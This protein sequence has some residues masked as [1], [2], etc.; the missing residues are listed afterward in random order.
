MRLAFQYVIKNKGIDSEL[1]YNYTG[2][3]G[4]CW[5]DATHRSIAQIDSWTAVPAGNEVRI[6]IESPAHM[7]PQRAVRCHTAAL[8]RS[9]AIS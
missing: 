6:S 8:A 2:E 7:A 5:S 4:Q 9:P 1:D 3:N